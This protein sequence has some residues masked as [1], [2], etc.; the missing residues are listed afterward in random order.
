MGP[1]RLLAVRR[2]GMQRVAGGVDAG[3]A[4]AVLAQLAL[5]GALLGWKGVIASL[6]GGSLLGSI[7]GIVVLAR[8]RQDVMRTEL[9]F[10]PYLAAAATFYLFAEP[11]VHLYFRLL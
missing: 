6:F 8:Q 7:I 3:E 2:S 11:W 4:R 5:I 10:G 1:V 9:P